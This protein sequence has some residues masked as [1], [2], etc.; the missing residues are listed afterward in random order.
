MNWKDKSLT[1]YEVVI[2]FIRAATTNTG[3]EVF[4][5]LDRKHHRKGR[6]FPDDDIKMVKLHPHPKHPG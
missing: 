1:I 3:L 6:D 4:A 2:N 5:R